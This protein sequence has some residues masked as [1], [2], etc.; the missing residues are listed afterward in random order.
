MQLVAQ[1]PAPVLL[2][3]ALTYQVFAV[4]PFVPV[5]AMVHEPFVPE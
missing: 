5:L 3:V 1:F 2:C 4:L